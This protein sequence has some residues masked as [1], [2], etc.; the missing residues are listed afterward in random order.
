M[1]NMIVPV[2][3]TNDQDLCALRKFIEPRKTQRGLAAATKKGTTE[4]TEKEG[5]TALTRI[6]HDVK[7]S[8]GWWS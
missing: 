6:I 3:L 5:R 7:Q 8:G 1:W 4:D 2:L